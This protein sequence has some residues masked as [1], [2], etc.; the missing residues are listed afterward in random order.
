M[1]RTL[2]FCGGVLLGLVAEAILWN[3]PDLY[4]Y[5]DAWFSAV[6]TR[7]VGL[8]VI[9]Q[10]VVAALGAAWCL[11]RAFVPLTSAPAQGG[12]AVPG[13]APAGVGGGSVLPLCG[14][15]F[16]LAAAGPLEQARF[17]SEMLYYRDYTHELAEWTFGVL[18]LAV[19]GALLAT[20]LLLR[21]RVWQLGWRMNGVGCG[22]AA[23]GLLLSG[24]GVLVCLANGLAGEGARKD[25]AYAGY[26]G[27]LGGAVLAVVGS[28]VAVVG[29]SWHP[30]EE[31]P[32][33]GQNPPADRGE[34]FED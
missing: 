24:M 26:L 8:G 31:Q 25:L 16:L 22:I 5:E 3:G 32:D 14:L 33:A 17:D 15:L 20:P 11:G 19:G 30:G 2:L 4:A 12:T 9:V 18:W 6:F 1:K 13:P 10:G 21:R 29:R 23:G 28:I 34:D 7:I 27:V